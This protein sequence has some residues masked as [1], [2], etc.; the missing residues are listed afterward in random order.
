MQRLGIRNSTAITCP[1][2]T[3]RRG[4]ILPSRGLPPDRSAEARGPNPRAAKSSYALFRNVLF[5]QR[6]YTMSKY[7]MRVPLLL[8]A[9]RLAAVH[10]STAQPLAHGRKEAF[11]H[12][13]ADRPNVKCF[14]R[15][16]H[17]LYLASLFT[18]ARSGR[19]GMQRPP[20]MVHADATLIPVRQR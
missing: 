14:G 9:G 1:P 8:L 12:R 6:H 3:T 16:V 20:A 15:W 10:S 11:K 18:T 2:V 19:V 17:Q 13:L 7:S 5:H 4:P